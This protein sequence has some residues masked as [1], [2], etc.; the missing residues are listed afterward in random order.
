[1]SPR[2]VPP[3]SKHASRGGPAT[4]TPELPSSCVR[5]EELIAIIPERAFSD[6]EA[7]EYFRQDDECPSGRPTVAEA[8]ADWGLR[9]DAFTNGDPE[10]GFPS[11]VDRVAAIATH[12]RR[13]Y[14]AQQ[15]LLAHRHDPNPKYHPRSYHDEDFPIT[16]WRINLEEWFTAQ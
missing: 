1:M 11:R 8:E 9:P 7:Q 12:L 5:F 16:K 3:P 13:A 2:R 10:R 14:Q 4:G 6:E 15:Y